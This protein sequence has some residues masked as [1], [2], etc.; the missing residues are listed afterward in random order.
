MVMNWAKASTTSAHQRRGL[1][2]V[3]IAVSFGAQAPA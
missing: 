2:A 3:C 1:I